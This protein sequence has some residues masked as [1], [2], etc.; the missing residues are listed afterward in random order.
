MTVR[1]LLDSTQ[2]QYEW[3][4]HEPAYSAQALAHAMHRSGHEVVK[5]VVIVADGEP[6]LCAVPAC[7]RVDP[8]EV[9][10]LLDAS[11][12][13]LADETLMRRTFA[14]CELGAEPPIGRLF[15]L[16]TLMDDALGDKQR[17]T[18]QAG[19]HRDAVTISLAD[20]VK[21]SDPVVGH[22]TFGET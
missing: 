1:Q 8:R 20:F 16:R 21:L 6:F 2:V 22:I 17:L 5:P 11:E 13:V 12:V 14:G 4:T 10:E 3:K 9:R 7:K 18:F 15:G 19:T